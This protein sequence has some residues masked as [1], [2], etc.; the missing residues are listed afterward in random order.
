M[1]HRLRYFPAVGRALLL[2]LSSLMFNASAAKTFD[3]N[4]AAEPV[5]VKKGVAQL[6][7]DD[8]LIAS[9][10]SLR[11]ALHQPKK[12]NGGNVPILALDNEYGGYRSTLEAN[13]T[14]IFDTRLKKYVM[15]AI[16]FSSHFP[17]PASE[18]IRI[19]RFTSPDAMNWLKGDE[20]TP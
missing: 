6:F 10:T 3:T 2:L 13:G 14:I 9:Q 7:A 18:R 20:G 11:R 16:G 19:Y 1:E 8:F 15:F 4:E 12:D 5:A 17:G